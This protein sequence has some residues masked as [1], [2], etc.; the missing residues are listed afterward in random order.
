MKASDHFPCGKAAR[1]VM[2]HT[3]CI[4]GIQ[5]IQVEG[6]VHGS[7]EIDLNSGIPVF[8]LDD[9]DTETPCLFGLVGIHAPDADLNEPVCKA[10]F[11]DPRKGTGMGEAVALEFLIEIRVCVEVKDLNAAEFFGISLYHRIGDGMIPSEGQDAGTT[12]EEGTRPVFNLIEGVGAQVEIADIL[13]SRLSIQV[14]TG[15]CKEVGRPGI[16]GLTDPWGGLCRSPH[17]CGVFVPWQ[18]EKG[19][20]TG[21]DLA[22]EVKGSVHVVTFL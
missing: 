7:L 20:G 2:G 15:F 19:D 5:D 18:S 12:L 9:F 10:V 4:G 8:H 14:H 21:L 17:E 11:H 3:G 6:Q 13:K 22:W 1:F 16:Q